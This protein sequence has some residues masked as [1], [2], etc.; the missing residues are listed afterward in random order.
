MPDNGNTSSLR[1]AALVR[2]STEKQE[3][4]GE[5]LR[6]QRNSIDRS[7]A[8]LGGRIVQWYGGQEHATP[9]WEKVEVDRLLADAQK[10]KFDAV[11]VAFASRWSRDNAKSKEGLEVFRKQGIRLFIGATETDLFKPTDRFIMGMHAEVGEFLALEQTRLSL[12]NRIE[13]ARRG[14]PSVGRIPYGRIYDKKT[15]QLSIDPNK[16]QRI[17][18]MAKR[19]LDGEPLPALAKAYGLSRVTAYETLRNASGDSW[20]LRFSSK[21]LNIDET[22]LIPVPRLLDQRTIKAVHQR[23]EANR[24]HLRGHPK[25]DYLLGGRV[26]CG[27]CG[28]VMRG[29]TCNGFVYYRHSEDGAKHCSLRPRPMVPARRLEEDV[30]SKLFDMFGNPAAIQRAIKAS[31]PDCDESMKRHR[32]LAD[33]LE[34]VKKA[35]QSVLALVAKGAVAEEEAEVQL[36]GLQDR[37]NILQRELDLLEASLADIPTEEQVRI[38]VERIESALHPDYPEINLTDD[39][40]NEYSGGNTIASWLAMTDA[41]KKKLVHAV[42]NGPPINEKPAGVYV[43]PGAG[44]AHRRRQW[45][46]ALRGRLEFEFAVSA[47]D[48]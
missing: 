37:V 46:F 45:T 4:Q 5:S 7:V 30:V 42:F 48:H 27:E 9:G 29:G 15:G 12:E 16:Q 3:Q 8:H 13:R 21:E 40:G 38:Y 47:A 20:T 35:R 19:Y 44:T 43:L 2:V 17:Q 10:K 34:R 32:R 23:M 39:Q 24:T 26:F 1:F 18:E 41:D 31:V 6:T 22:V 14:V 36:R 33:D 28:Y 25:H 11:I